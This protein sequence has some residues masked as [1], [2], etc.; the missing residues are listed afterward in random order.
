MGG[1][2]HN[3]GCCG[4][5]IIAED[6]FNRDGLDLGTGWTH[7]TDEWY[8]YATPPWEDGYAL[9]LAD[10]AIAINNTSHPVPD[11][12]GVVYLDIIGETP[13]SGKAYR[14]IINAVDKDSYH[15]AE[16]IRHGGSDSILRLGI[17]SSG[18]DTILESKVIDGLTDP[19]L[20]PRRLTVMIADDEF[21]ATV[22]HCVFSFVTVEEAVIPNGYKAGFGGDDGTQF[23]HWT[24][25]QHAQTKEECPHCLCN[26]E[27]N[28]IPP[29][30][31]ANLVGTGRMST[32]SCDIE[33]VWSRTLGAWISTV[34]TCCN[35]G[36]Q[37]K[38]FC[39]ETPADVTTAKIL[40]LVGC[41][42]SDVTGTGP[43]YISAGVRWAN[44][45]ST[46]TPISLVFGPFDVGSLD[47]NCGCPTIGAF[48][49]GTYTITVTL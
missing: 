44:S 27:T 36:W 35:Q 24:Y 23:S 39:P 25:L 9:S 47:F 42:D 7:E 34:V 2:K 38:L 48:G 26:C 19:T 31:N 11:E 5:C 28:Y 21:C 14:A 6:D 22:S 10:G 41:I 33:L 16:Y 20:E 18:T 13:D 45:T 8:T 49:S 32:L 17:S 40:V 46:C 30:L 4:G 37:L 43:D 3:K 15:F 12:S 29:I 1:G